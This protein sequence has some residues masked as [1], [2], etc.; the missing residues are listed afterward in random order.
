MLN[1]TTRKRDTFSNKLYLLTKKKKKLNKLWE[2]FNDLQSGFS[3]Y[4][5]FCT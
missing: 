3:L 4:N 5:I 2:D 1:V